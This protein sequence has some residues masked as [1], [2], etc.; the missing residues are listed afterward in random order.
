MD[1]KGWSQDPP[2]LSPHLRVGSRDKEV[3][4]ELPVPVRPSEGK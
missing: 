3:L 1:L 2:L 4:L